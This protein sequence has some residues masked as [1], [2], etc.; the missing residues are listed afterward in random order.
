MKLLGRFAG[1]VI[2]YKVEK[3]FGFIRIEGELVRDGIVECNDYRDQAFIHYKD[4]EPEQSHK[5]NF[6]KLYQGDQVQFDLHREGPKLKAKNLTSNGAKYDN[7]GEINGN[8]ETID[9]NS[10]G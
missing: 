3:G 5:E 8:K 6:K 9:S 1:T 4:I 10:I 2:D 7:D